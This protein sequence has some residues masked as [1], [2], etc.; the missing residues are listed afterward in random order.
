MSIGM[1]EAVGAVEEIGRAE[2][3]TETL[4]ASRPGDPKAFRRFVVRYEPV[5]FAYLSR[6][7]GPGPHVEDLAQEVFLKAFRA[8]TRFVPNGP[9][10]ASTWLLTIATRVAI[11]ARKRKRVPLDPFPAGGGPVDPTTP[12]TER[13]RHEMRHRLGHALS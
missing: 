6:T 2:L 10:R 1:V 3:E 13:Q 12:E 7:L 5:V 8:V 4:E 9:A 11:D